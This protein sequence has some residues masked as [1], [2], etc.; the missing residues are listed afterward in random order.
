MWVWL[1]DDYPVGVV[2]CVGLRW[3]VVCLF[4]SVCF[5]ILSLLLQTVFWCCAV[6][7]FD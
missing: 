1:F 5:V 7:M 4:S 3:V 6:V 2:F